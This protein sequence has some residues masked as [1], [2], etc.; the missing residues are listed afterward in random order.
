ME[1]GSAVGTA[2]VKSASTDSDEYVVRIPE[3]TGRIVHTQGTR[4]GS[5]QT[6]T[7]PLVAHEAFDEVP[8]GEYRDSSSS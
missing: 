6:T 5:S 8:K 2:G 3:E 7:K 1:R 4:Q